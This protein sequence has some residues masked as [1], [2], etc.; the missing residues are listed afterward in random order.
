MKSSESSVINFYML[1]A[2]T[3]ALLW[4]H[5]S[6]SSVV[7]NFYVLTAMPFVLIHECIHRS[8]INPFII[9][10]ASLPNNTF[11]QHWF[12]SYSDVHTLFIIGPRK[13]AENWEKKKNE[14]TKEFFALYRTAGIEALPARLL[15]ISTSFITPPAVG[16]GGGAAQLARQ[17]SRHY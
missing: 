8:Q 14:A 9:Y 6:K 11:K 10:Y 3:F 16:W 7:I 17:L 4:V 13:C 15:Y 5:W 1:T 2:L 12:Y